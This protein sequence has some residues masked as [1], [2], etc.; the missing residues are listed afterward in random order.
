MARKLKVFQAPFGFYDSVVAASSQAAAL[1]AWGTHQNLFAEGIAGVT[2]DPKAVE[3]ALAHPDIPLRRAIGSDAP[4]ELEPS[5][6]PKAPK[7]PK[8]EKVQKAARPA[9]KP[10]PE[11]APPD[12]SELDEAEASLK[13]LDD[14]WTRRKAEFAR[15]RAELDADEEAA[16]ESY[17]ED[18]TLRRRSVEAAK[19]AFEKA[20]GKA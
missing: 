13:R 8:G 16:Q 3:A 5:V 1:R 19:A 9:A 2:D 15:R 7:L 12:R 11:P 17:D 20:A 14:G 18:R 4:F 10:K 6:K